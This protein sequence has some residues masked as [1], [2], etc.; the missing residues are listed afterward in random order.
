MIKKFFLALLALTFH[1]FPRDRHLWVTGK[2]TSWGFHNSP[3]VFFDN[4]KYFFLYL[5]NHTNERVYWLSSSKKEIHLLTRM[6]L[7]V[8]RYPSIRG[9]FLVLRAKYSFHHYGPDQ[10][11]PILQRGSIQLDFWHGTPL[12]KIRYDVVEKPV[13]EKKWFKEL[14]SRGGTE[15][16]FSTSSYLSETIFKRAFAVNQ[17]NLLNFGYPRMDVMALERDDN[18]KFCRE[19]SPEL[20]PYIEMAKEHDKVFLYMPTFRDDDPEYFEK[21]AID[22]DAM[23]KKLYEINGIIFLKLHPVTKYTAIKKYE[24]IVQI[25]NDVDIYPFLIYTDFLITDYSSIFF[26]YLILDKE[27]IFIPYDYDNYVCNRQLYFDYNS[28]TPGKKY[29]SFS[30][31]IS[32]LD[33]IANLD[34]HEERRKVKELLFDEYSFDACKRTYQFIKKQYQER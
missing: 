32:D 12:K 22:M 30:K 23:S 31:F 21:A 17:S 24:N 33:S 27:M 28:I 14:I 11:E 9:I 15:Y 18:I 10:I 8:V 26:D 4:S 6:G 34:F 19:Y 16:I 13:E 20:I 25:R 29:S 3:P 5:V 7:P 2:I 1:P